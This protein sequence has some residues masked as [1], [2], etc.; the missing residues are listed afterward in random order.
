LTTCTATSRT[1]R[2]RWGTCPPTAG[3]ILDEVGEHI[4]AARAARAALDTE[5]EAGVRTVLER[6]GD[7]ADIAAE[8]RERFGV[9]AR[10]ASTRLE[11]VALV[12]LVIPFIG[13]VVGV[14]LVLVSRL[15]TARDKLIATLCGMS[16]VAAGLGTI[17]MSVRASTP[18]G[19]GPPGPSET[20][21]LEVVLF[22]LP[23]LLPVAAAIYLA[24]RLRTITGELEQRSAEPR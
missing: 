11:T 17:S 20:S 23:F 4:G 2:P 3:G 16:W 8:A 9:P 24:I 7:P 10:P 21:L 6:L 19:S 15:W 12:L 22:V 1:W 18:V 5:T 14:V 13:W